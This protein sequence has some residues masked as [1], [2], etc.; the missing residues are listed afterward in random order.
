LP[1]SRDR[2]T[3]HLVL[4]TNPH[5]NIIIMKIIIPGRVFMNYE[6]HRC[7]PSHAFEPAASIHRLLVLKH[8]VVTLI[9]IVRQRSD[10]R[11]TKAAVDLAVVTIGCDV[12][13][14]VILEVDGPVRIEVIRRSCEVRE[15]V[16]FPDIGNSVNTA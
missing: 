13:I 5:L 11:I 15:A 7:L 6:L 10:R 3:S 2:Q 16:T 9:D 1:L 14:L 4:I 12:D 8:D